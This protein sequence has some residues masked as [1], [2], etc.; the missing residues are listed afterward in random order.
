MM[1]RFDITERIREIVKELWEAKVSDAECINALLVPIYEA[2]SNGASPTDK[3]VQE[4]GI[5]S[6]VRVFRWKSE[7]MKKKIEKLSW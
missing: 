1:S 2:I 5:P 6:L 3:P 7:W 4:R